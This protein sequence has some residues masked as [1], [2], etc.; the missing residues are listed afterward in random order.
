MGG[1][2]FVVF[3][4]SVFCMITVAVSSAVSAA[5][6][7]RILYADATLKSYQWPII[8]IVVLSIAFGLAPLLVFTPRL[9]EEKRA[10]WGRYTRFASEYVWRFEKKWLDARSSEDM[11]GSGDI[12][13]L[14]DIGGSFERMVDMRVVVLDRRAA[15]SFMASAVAP[16]LPLLLTM[17]PLRDIVRILF[18]ALI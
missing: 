8:G 2:G 15:I 9:V 18:K 17:M 11:L 7:N 10:A 6:A 5:A 4:Q 16:L 1:L 13:S 3:H 14:A 12:Q